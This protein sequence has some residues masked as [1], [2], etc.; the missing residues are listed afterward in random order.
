M[1]M[2]GTGMIVE[3]IENVFSDP[4]AIYSQMI[5]MEVSQ[6]PYEKIVL[7]QKKLI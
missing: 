7:V 4:N 1:G 2:F 6:L 5:E 3:S